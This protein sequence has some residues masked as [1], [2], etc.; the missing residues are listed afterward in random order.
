MCNAGDWAPNPPLQQ[1]SQ[2]DVS[3]FLEAQPKELFLSGSGSSSSSVAALLQT[4]VRGTDRKMDRQREGERERMERTLFPVYRWM[5]SP[6]AA[7]RTNTTVY[8]MPADTEI[9]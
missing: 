7:S 4:A 9:L 8:M 1:Q 6:A 3:S 5:F 2:E